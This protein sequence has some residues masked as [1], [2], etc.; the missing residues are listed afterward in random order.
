MSRGI[1][2]K[3]IFLSSVGSLPLHIKVRALQDIDAKIHDCRYGVQQ[4]KVI[5]RDK[6]NPH[7]RLAAKSRIRDFDQVLKGL[8]S[9]ITLYTRRLQREELLD[10]AS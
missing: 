4:M 1:E 3:R 10:G 7:L 5:V 8:E 6:V 2:N 9:D